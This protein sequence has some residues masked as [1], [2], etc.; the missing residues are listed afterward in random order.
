M[1]N[2]RLQLTTLLLLLLPG[3][4]AKTSAGE[5][6]PSGTANAANG[7]SITLPAVAGTATQQ[8]PADRPIAESDLLE[9]TVFEVPELSRVVRV[10]EAGE[11]S[12]PL[13]GVTAAAGKTP[14]QL[15]ASLRGQLQR[16][17]MH[18]PQVTVEVKELG[19]PPIYVIGEVNKP[20]ALVATGR[21]TLTVLRALAMAEGTKSTAAGKLYVIRPGPGGERSQ[22]QISIKDLVRGKTADLALQANDVVYV[23]KST[24]RS[25]ALGAVDVLLRTVTFRT[26][27]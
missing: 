27:F 21:S 18:D 7:G 25:L 16:T 19:T 24:E 10:S 23:P 15:E 20:G 12:L 26:V 1:R 9:I 14:R 3:C 22:M 17:Y 11:I 2:T 6:V 8:A 5:P 4:A 13:I